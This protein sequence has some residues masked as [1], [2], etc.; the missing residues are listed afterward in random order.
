MMLQTRQADPTF[1]HLPLNQL[2]EAALDRARSRGARRASVLVTRVRTAR[3]VVFDGRPQ[4]SSDVVATGL[5]VRTESEGRRGFAATVDLTPEAAAA[6]ADRAI[7]VGQACSA[8]PSRLLEPV[9]EPVHVGEWVSPYRIDPFSVPESERVATLVDWSTRLTAAPEVDLVMAKVT[10]TR[11]NKFYADL[12][13]SRTL[14]QRIRVHPQV[15]AV[16]GQASLRSQGPPT[17]RG[18]EYLAGDGWD[19]AAELA[20]LPASLAEKCRAE[21]VEP[22]RYDLVIDPSQLW[23]TIHESIGHATEL[24]RALGHEAGYAGTTFVS[25]YELGSL[26]YGSPLLDVDA[27]RTTPH[28]L[29]T[30][31]FDD[32]GVAAQRWPLIEHGVLTGLQTDRAG[33]AALGADRSTGCA[34]AESALHVPLQRMPNVSVRAAVDGPD[35][36]ELISSVGDGIYLTGSDSFSIDMRREDFQFSAQRAY[37]IR[38]G[39]LAG[40]L[41]GVAYRGR[42]RQFWSALAAIGGSRTYRTF[43]ADLCGK[44][45]PVQA[46]ATSHGSPSAVFAGVQVTNTGSR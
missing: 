15:V 39:E 12:G 31:G 4:G 24:D 26:G 2:A 30:T 8:L 5:A 18:W 10:V 41:S 29:A 38:N 22:G 42:T 36:A 20:E 19:W 43:G 21:P 9:A 13:G 14:Q 44:G 35:T 45:Q 3:S 34:Y 46:A 40:Q 32:E 7:E 16:G 11:E 37:R 33:A 25:P 6:T 1:L 27:D 23:L 17:A 28:A